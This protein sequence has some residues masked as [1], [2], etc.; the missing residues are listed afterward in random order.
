MQS[1]IGKNGRFRYYEFYVAQTKDE[2]DTK[3]L[4]S[5]YSSKGDINYTSFLSALVIFPYPETGRYISLRSFDHGL[6]GS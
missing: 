2:L 4:N 6:Y 3:I 1:Q 5:N